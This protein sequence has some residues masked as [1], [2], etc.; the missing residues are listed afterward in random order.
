MKKLILASLALTCAASVFAQGTVVLNTRLSGTIFSR[1]YAPKAG[2][3]TF[4]QIGNGNTADEVPKGTTDWTGFTA[5]SGAGYR[6]VLFS[7]PGVN[8]A[9]D[10]LKANSMFVTFRTGTAAGQIPQTTYTLDNVPGGPGG[11]TLRLFVWDNTT[12]KYD[13]AALAFN[14]WQQGLIAGGWSGLINITSA[15][16][17]G[18]DKPPTVT[19]L[20]SFN[21]YM[22]PEPSSM[23]LAGLGA[24]AL[25]IF[26]RRK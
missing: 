4:H 14:A 5:I 1:V 6:G 7:A 20:E 11:A 18:L 15:L 17:G 16:G 12:A 10:S 19:G 21:I 3:P 22:V 23:A 2:D 24:A 13:T 9:V 8:A 26:R 25:L